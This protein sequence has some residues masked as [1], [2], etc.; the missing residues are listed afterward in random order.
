MGA[1]KPSPICCVPEEQKI[2]GT[3]CNAV[4]IELNLFTYAAR[5]ALLL[6]TALATAQSVPKNHIPHLTP[7]QWR[8]DLHALASGITRHHKNAFHFTHKA[9]FEAAVADLDR[10]IPSLQSYQ[11]TVAMMGILAMVG[12]GHTR[13]DDLFNSFSQFPL[14]LYWF[15]GELRVIRTTLEYKQA[16]GGRVVAIGST[17]ILNANQKVRSIIEQHETEDWVKRFSAF[18]LASPEVLAYFGIINNLDQ[19]TYSIEKDGKVFHLA[20][21]SIAYNAE[22]AYLDA[23]PWLPLYR[24]HNDRVWFTYMPEAN[25]A[26]LAFNCYP[27]A[28]QFRQI[29]AS[30]FQTL[31]QHHGA[32]LA[33]DFRNNGGGDY[34]EFD[35]LLLDG[36]KS[37]KWLFD[38]NRL[39]GLVGKKTFSAAM[40]NVLQLRQQMHAILV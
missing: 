36:L 10:C 22:P 33:I 35:S 7:D 30:L 19:A 15:G 2:I 16:L 1:G 8:E 9:K 12:D 20:I 14:D 23:A 25:L 21:D 6:C 32:A 38:R 17:P 18:Y 28:D 3:G 34:M 29:A 31:D 39:F 13:S 26:Y 37:R 4:S 40:M 5:V 11:I 27:A 24:Q